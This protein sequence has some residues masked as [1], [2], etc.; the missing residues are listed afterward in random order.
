MLNINKSI[1][2]AIYNDTENAIDKLKT[3]IKKPGKLIKFKTS[4]QSIES[5]KTWNSKF[6]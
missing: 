4:L 5:L 3:R 1:K 2:F 6:K